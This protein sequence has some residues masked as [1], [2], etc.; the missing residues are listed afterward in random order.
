M[1]VLQ[2]E[3]VERLLAEWGSEDEVDYIVVSDGE[4]VSDCRSGLGR[5]RIRANTGTGVYIDFRDWRSG[6]WWDWD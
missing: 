4:E 2:K 1:N 3:K 5:G 6:C